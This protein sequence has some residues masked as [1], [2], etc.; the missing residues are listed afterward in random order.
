M[1][2]IPS[3]HGNH[4]VPWNKGRLI[5]QKPPLKL[6][7]IWA[8]RI[9]LQISNQVRDLA[10]RNGPLFSDSR[11]SNGMDNVDVIYRGY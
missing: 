6:Q 11:L 9:R 4:Y 5:G 10:L 1:T 7:E 3:G 2:L 8:I